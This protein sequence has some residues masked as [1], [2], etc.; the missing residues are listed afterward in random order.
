MQCVTIPLPYWWIAFRII[1]A[2]AVC[3]CVMLYIGSCCSR[4][5][6]PPNSLYFA[7]KTN[8]RTNERNRINEWVN[9]R[10]ANVC[11]GYIS[12]TSR[13]NTYNL[14]SSIWDDDDFVHWRCLY[15]SIVISLTIILYLYLY[16][17]TRF[18]H[19][20]LLPDSFCFCCVLCRSVFSSFDLRRQVKYEKI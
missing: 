16:H 15:P 4:M 14:Y 10:K 13:L 2:I 19:F 7:I 6:S 20:P 18:W 1:F 17:G 8:Q 5:Y 3:G 9:K 12:Y 11:F